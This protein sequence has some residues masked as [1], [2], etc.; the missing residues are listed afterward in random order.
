[1]DEVG[2]VPA[3]LGD[4]GALTKPPVDIGREPQALAARRQFIRR[5]DLGPEP[6]GPEEVLAGGYGGGNVVVGPNAAVV[7]AG[8]AGDMGEGLLARD[9]PPSPADDDHQLSFVVEGV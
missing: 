5:D 3:H 7:V 8:V 4:V 1:M 2:Y 9:H 6:S